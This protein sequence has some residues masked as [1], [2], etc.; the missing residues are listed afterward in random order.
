MSIA[1]PRIAAYDRRNAERLLSN[2]KDLQS[3]ADA[4]GW[5]HEAEKECGAIGMYVAQIPSFR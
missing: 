1:L 3:F 4:R 5:D 2:F